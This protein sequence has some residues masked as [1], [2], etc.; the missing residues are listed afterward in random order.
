MDLRPV[1]RYNFQ[2]YYSTFVLFY[3]GIYS[4]IQIL[5]PQILAPDGNNRW[6]VSSYDL[7]KLEE[8]KGHWLKVSD[9]FS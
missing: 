9:P 3:K 8:R 7:S 1:M 6:P 2:E 5:P 4:P